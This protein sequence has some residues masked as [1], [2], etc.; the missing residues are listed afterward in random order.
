MSEMTSR[1][2]HVS[3]VLAVIATLVVA[4]CAGSGGATTETAPAPVAST[5]GPDAATRSLEGIYRWILTDEDAL[6]HGTPADKTKEVLDRDYPSTLTVTLSSG[7]WSM[8]QTA[9]P[10]IYGGTYQATADR[11]TF[12]WPAE[13]TVLIFTYTLADG[14]LALRPV[15]PIDV[16]DK[17]VWTTRTWTK[18]S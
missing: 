17:F 7:T 14:R 16:G 4:G 15:E 1:Q 10:E 6:A 18:I 5:A 8:Q 3:A 9:S 12:N 2:R 11:L 13:Q